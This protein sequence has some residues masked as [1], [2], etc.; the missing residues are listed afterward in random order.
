MYRTDFWTLWEKARVGCFK[1]TASKHVYY[2]WWNRSPAQ[3]GCMRWVLMTGALGRCRGMGW[4][5]WWE[6][7]SGWGTHVNPCLIHVNVWQKPLQYYKVISLQWIKINGKEL[8]SHFC[9]LDCFRLSLYRGLG[10]GEKFKFFSGLFEPISFQVHTWRPSIISVYASYFTKVLVF[11][12]W[13]QKE[14][15]DGRRK[16]YRPLNSLEVTS[17]GSGGGYSQGGEMHQQWLLPLSA[18]MVQKKQPVIRTQTLGI[19]GERSY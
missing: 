6:G 19:G 16:G 13:L 3:V 4:R 14:K 7:G 12:V 2:L 8:P 1:R 11:N 10:S 5:G 17:A 15:H 18:H 9:S